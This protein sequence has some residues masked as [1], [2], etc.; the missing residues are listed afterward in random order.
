M[1]VRVAT[2][3]YRGHHLQGRFVMAV[4]WSFGSKGEGEHRCVQSLWHRDPLSQDNQNFNHQYLQMWHESQTDHSQNSS[5]HR[6]IKKRR[7]L[8]GIERKKPDKRDVQGRA[9]QLVESLPIMHK[10]LRLIPC[11]YISLA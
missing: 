8:K 9:T 7:P 5:G 3:G 2:W 6:R 1:D 11:N 10:V 4:K